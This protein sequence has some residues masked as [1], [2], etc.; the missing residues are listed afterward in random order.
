MKYYLFVN[1]NNIVY[2][3]H[4]KPVIGNDVKEYEGTEDFKFYLEQNLGRMSFINGVFTILP[5]ISNT[6]EKTE[7]DILRLKRKIECFSVINRGKLWYDS[8]TEIQLQELS[9]WYQAWLNVTITLIA[10]G[11]PSWLE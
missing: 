10:P 5:S 4:I 8:L 3:Y 6:I 9:T 1:E 11:K 7:V 2:G